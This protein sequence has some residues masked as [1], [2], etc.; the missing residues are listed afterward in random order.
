MK[1]AII[2]TMRS[3]SSAYQEMV[4]VDYPGISNLHEYYTNA[5]HRRKIFD[6]VA[7]TKSLFEE[8]SHFTNKIQGFNLVDL[9]ATPEVLQLERYDRILLLE[10][11]DF[12]EK[13][14]S[15]QVSSDTKIFNL[16]R[17][18]AHLF[19]E[20]RN[21]KFTLELVRVRRVANDLAKYLAIKKYIINQRIPYEFMTYDA[22]L[23]QA[24]LENVTHMDNNY[25]YSKMIIN[26]HLRDTINSLADE[27]FNFLTC[28][29]KTNIFLKEVKALFK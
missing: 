4:S 19:D 22:L 14:C 12:F 7:I 1:I 5:T 28:L 27:C 13:C 20:H 21:Q 6:P 2:S 16:R 11:Y 10:R 18:H 8:H 15:Y 24:K 26:Y 25:D 3:G 29:A 9:K 23:S 17:R